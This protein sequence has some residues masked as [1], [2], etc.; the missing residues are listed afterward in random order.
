MVKLRNHGVYGY[1]GLTA[2]FE[3]YNLQ[4]AEM[5]RQSRE[6][7]LQPYCSQENVSSNLTRVTTRSLKAYTS[8]CREKNLNCQDAVDTEYIEPIDGECPVEQ[9]GR[10]A[11]PHCE[12][13]N[14]CR[15]LLLTDH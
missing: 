1:P 2:R 14:L 3:G 12:G 9:T 7:Y 15:F 11:N 4:C 8:V 13:P 10:G 5:N 6:A